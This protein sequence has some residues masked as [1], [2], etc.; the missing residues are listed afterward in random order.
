MHVWCVKMNASVCI[1]CIHAEI[2]CCW[3][4]CSDGVSQ[5]RTSLA[6]RAAVVCCFCLEILERLKRDYRAQDSSETLT[7]M[8]S[9]TPTRSFHSFSIVICAGLDYLQSFLLNES[10]SWRRS[11]PQI[12]LGSS[13]CNLKIYCCWFWKWQLF[14][15]QNTSYTSLLYWYLFIFSVLFIYLFLIEVS[16]ALHYSSLQCHMIVQKSF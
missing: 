16:Y 4:V 10:R 8:H 13:N 15:Y 9:K 7:V 6:H 1:S 14:I 12:L 3:D 11:P 2:M 5:R